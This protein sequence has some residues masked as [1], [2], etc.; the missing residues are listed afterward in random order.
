MAFERLQELGERAARRLHVG[1]GS[2]DEGDRDERF[3]SPAVIEIELLEEQ[4]IVRRRTVAKE[5]IAIDV[6]AEHDTRRVRAERRI[7]HVDEEIDDA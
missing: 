7:E 6:P 1:H 2:S 3:G 4:P 5:R